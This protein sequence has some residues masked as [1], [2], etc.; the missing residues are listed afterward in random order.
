MATMKVKESHQKSEVFWALYHGNVTNPG[1]AQHPV[2]TLPR[3][4]RPVPSFLW[5]VCPLALPH[6]L[7]PHIT[8][9]A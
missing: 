3:A 6:R 8:T 1:F 5:P 2:H 9:G 7:D 4:Q